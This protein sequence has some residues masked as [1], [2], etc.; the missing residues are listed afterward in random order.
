[1]NP[2]STDINTEAKSTTLIYTYRMKD[3][4]YSLAKFTCSGENL[5]RKKEFLEIHGFPILIDFIKSN[6]CHMVFL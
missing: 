1:M 5:G 4:G 2:R 6:F 3:S